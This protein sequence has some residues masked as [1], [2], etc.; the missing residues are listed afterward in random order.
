LGGYGLFGT[1]SFPEADKFIGVTVVTDEASFTSFINICNRCFV[2]SVE[3]FGR[4]VP[5]PDY[6][7]TEVKDACPGVWPALRRIKLYRVYSD[8][9]KPTPA[10][11]KEIEQQF[12]Q[13]LGSPG[14]KTESDSFFVLQQCVLDG[15]ME[16]IQIDLNLPAMWVPPQSTSLRGE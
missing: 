4:V 9:A 12:R 8:H 10:Y 7:R 16:G 6:F 15:L 3:A 11:A 13:D 14:P 5:K 1:A 2:E